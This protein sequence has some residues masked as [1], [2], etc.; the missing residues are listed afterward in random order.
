MHRSQTPPPMR[1]SPGS[2]GRRLVLVS[3]GLIPFCGYG[4]DVAARGA[5]QDPPPVVY[6]PPVQLGLVEDPAIAESSGLARALGRDDALWTHNDS[7]D[8]ARLFLIGTDGRTL[9][10]AAIEGLAPLDWEDLC[11]FQRR[12]KNYLLVG[13]VG[14]NRQRRPQLELCLVEEP[15]VRHLPTPAVWRLRPAALIPLRLPDGAHDVEALAVDATSETVLLASKSLGGNAA[16]Y[17]APLCF[18]TPASPVTAHRIGAADI[19]FATGMDISPDGRRA[20]IVSYSGA[21][22]FTRRQGEDWAAA[23]ASSPR[24]L[25]MPDRRQGEAICYGADGR[26]L[27]LTSEGRSQ[28]LWLVPARKSAEPAVNPTA[29]TRNPNIELRNKPE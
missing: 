25:R 10:T 27:Y 19:P 24:V 14:D 5:E 4:P 13:D 26:S 6:D 16:F 22:E 20:M 1:T 9:G 2:L 18:T 12:G 11:S 15:D 23:F 17:Q 8:S 29:E 28:P 7:G 21:Y 3:L